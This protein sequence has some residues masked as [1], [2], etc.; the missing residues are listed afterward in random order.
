MSTNTLSTTLV[1]FQKLSD[2]IMK[3]VLETMGTLKG[4]DVIYVTTDCECSLDEVPCT[5]KTIAVKTS[6][7]G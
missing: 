5:I 7:Y 3:T 1:T 2:S 4:C 6:E